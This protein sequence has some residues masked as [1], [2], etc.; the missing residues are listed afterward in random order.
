VQHLLLVDIVEPS[1]ELFLASL[2]T[3]SFTSAIL[4]QYIEDIPALYLL[5]C[6]NNAFSYSV[7]IALRPA[8]QRQLYIWPPFSQP[9]P[10]T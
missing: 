6:I 5:D 9:A 4:H 10:L 1:H 7:K 3:W 8:P 2:V